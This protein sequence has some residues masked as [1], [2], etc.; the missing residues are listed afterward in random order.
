MIILEAATTLAGG[1]SVASQVTSTVFGMELASGVE[2]YKV[3]DQRQLAA[4][5]AT[6]Y[7]V[8][9]ST[10]AFIKA[11]HVVNNDSS[12][13]TFQ[14]FRSGT[15]AANAITPAI[16]VPAGGMAIYEDGQGWT[17][18]DSAGKIQDSDSSTNL[19]VSSLGVD[20]AAN[21]T[22][23]LAAISGLDLTLEVGTWQYQY[24]IRYQ[25][26][27]A[28]T[29]VKFAVDHQGT[30]SMHQYNGRYVSL[31]ATAASAAAS[32]A[33]A[34]TA[35]GNL[36]EG[37]SARADNTTIG[38]TVSVDTLNADMLFVIEGQLIVTAAGAL[39]L[40]HASEVA[41]ASTVKAGSSLV[42]IKVG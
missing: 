2:T 36:M 31:G 20:A 4:S 6:I 39:R 27:A 38:P 11:I 37:F 29:G 21:S 1:A 17:V 5:P 9:A 42:A 12:P 22:T 8:P 25:S 16:T 13:R 30:V 15:A 28:T 41:A 3:L 23:T 7:T 32:Q 18:F 33:A 40:T 19:R 10:V 14:Y 26:A 34:A 24:M 35:T